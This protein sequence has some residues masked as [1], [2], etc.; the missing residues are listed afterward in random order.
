MRIAN[1]PC[2]WG[3]LE[4]EGVA[5]RGPG[6]QNVLAEISATG[7]R[8][9]ELGDW[10]FL[11]TD[12]SALAEALEQH[13]LELVGAFVPV[14]FADPAA[15]AE[16]T[17]TALRTAKLVQAVAPNAR[18]VL[19]DDN[20]SV[21]LRTQLAGRI[22][23]EHGLSLQG[24]KHFARGA[25]ETA[26]TVA[27]ETGLVPVFHHHCAGFVE[28]PTEIRQLLDLTDSE[29]VGLCLDTGHFAFG[30]GDPC[31]AIRQYGARIRHVHFKDMSE[32][33]SAEVQGRDGDYFEAV[34]SG[35]FCELGAGSVDF[36]A[37]LAELRSID[38]NDWIV[39]EQDVLPSMGSPKESAT[40][41]RDYLE[42]IGL[43]R[44]RQP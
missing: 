10:G 29:V 26:R 31:S 28:T 20:G 43:G 17:S 1:A 30:G 40:R 33:I 44:E 36:P 2:S 37:V 38:Y 19:S 16:G 14:A 9:T 41:N 6:W 34:K 21:P 18:I 15:H 42:S 24:W 22:G 4:F 5:G 7:Y 23:T 12:P 25:E 39:V 32:Q 35:V 13:D 8:G 27:E 11:P 3:V